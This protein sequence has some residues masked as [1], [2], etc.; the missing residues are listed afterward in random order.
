[1]AGDGPLFVG[2]ILWHFPMGG[3]CHKIGARAKKRARPTHRLTPGGGSCSFSGDM[4]S[5]F[6][7]GVSKSGGEVPKITRK[8]ER[9][10][11]RPYFL[12]FEGSPGYLFGKCYVLEFKSLL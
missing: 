4:V 10:E 3:G 2:L 6:E 5:W 9:M 11:A 8:P 12:A 7:V 1:M